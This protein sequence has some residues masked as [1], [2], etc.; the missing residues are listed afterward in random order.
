MKILSFFFFVA[1]YFSLCFL[2]FSSPPWIH[3]PSAITDHVI[4]IFSFS[5]KWREKKTIMSNTGMRWSMF[6]ICRFWWG[7]ISI[8]THTHT[9][10]TPYTTIQNAYIVGK[11]GH[12][13]DF[14]FRYVF[15]ADKNDKWHLVPSAICLICHSTNPICHTLHTYSI[16]YIAQTLWNSLFCAF[17]YLIGT[18]IPL[19]HIIG[20]RFNFIP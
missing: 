17:L 3:N 9:H 5:W 16:K 11:T 12:S 1:F 10:T 2:F 7:S 14:C 15:W 8:D 20:Q 19:I 6:N 13:L 4:R 18:N